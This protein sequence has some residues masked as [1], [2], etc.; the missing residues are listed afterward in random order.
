[1][2][3]FAVCFTFGG[4]EHRASAVMDDPDAV[5]FYLTDLEY[6]KHLP[7]GVD[8]VA[9]YKWVDVSYLLDTPASDLIH[10]AAGEVALDQYEDHCR[11]DYIEPEDYE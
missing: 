7:I 1:M 4:Y 8:G 11:E 10:E 9:K 2:S 5:D 3:D 6:K